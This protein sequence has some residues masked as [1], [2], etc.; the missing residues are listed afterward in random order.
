MA[1]KTRI[2]IS[3][4]HTLEMRK[5]WK[6]LYPKEQASDDAGLQRPRLV[7]LQPIRA[8]QA[9]TSVF[10][11]LRTCTVT[12]QIPGIGQMTRVMLVHAFR[13]PLIVSYVL[14]SAHVPSIQIGSKCRAL[15][16]LSATGI[17]EDYYSEAMLNEMH[18]SY[19]QSMLS[20]QNTMKGQRTTCLH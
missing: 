9:P 5:S 14:L 15:L 17:S 19:S 6:T 16:L 13:R 18:K 10:G 7:V 12:D 2:W 1:L 3:C 20:F 11:L 8:A 4:P